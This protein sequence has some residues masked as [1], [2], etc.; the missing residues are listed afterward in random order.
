MKYIFE[1]TFEEE[2]IKWLV[3]YYLPNMV[4]EIDDTMEDDVRKTITII[5]NDID[6]AAKY[7]QQY[8]ITKQKD[9]NGEDWLDAEVLSIE[10]M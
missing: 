7:A 6:S 2:E 4:P 9:D 3:T 5:A 8:I 1:D 10:R